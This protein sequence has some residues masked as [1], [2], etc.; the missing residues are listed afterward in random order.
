MKNC[1]ENTDVNRGST[2]AVEPFKKKNC[3]G[4]TD[5]NRNIVNM[6]EIGRSY[7]FQYIKDNNVKFITLRHNPNGVSKHF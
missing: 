3:G 2:R 5:V 1:G 6:K 7:I 4:N